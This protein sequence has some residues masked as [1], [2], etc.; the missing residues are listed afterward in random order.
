[1]QRLGHYDSLVLV[2]QL[3]AQEAAS[4][5]NNVAC[6]VRLLL[7]RLL[8]T[9]QSLTISSSNDS[10]SSSSVPALRLSSA[11]SSSSSSCSGGGSSRLPAVAVATQHG[12]VTAYGIG[13]PARLGRASLLQASTVMADLPASSVTVGATRPWPCYSRCW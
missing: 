5:N 10:S 3:A 9:A 12:G 2:K 8:L 1:M 13:Y 6:V 4:A 11:S 7:V